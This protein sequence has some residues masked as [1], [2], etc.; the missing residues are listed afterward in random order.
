MKKVILLL[1]C[2]FIFNV[3]SATYKYEDVS[4]V[5]TI[6]GEQYVVSVRFQDNY[7]YSEDKDDESRYSLDTDFVTITKDSEI[8]L[9]N[10]PIMGSGFCLSEGKNTEQCNYDYEFS[11]NEIFDENG[12]A[13]ID[14]LPKFIKFDGLY[15]NNEADFLYYFGEEDE[16]LWNSLRNF[17]GDDDRV[18]NNQSDVWFNT[19]NKYEYE[20]DGFWD[21]FIHGD[22]VNIY[23]LP[24]SAYINRADN[25][26]KLLLEAS[27][28]N[29][30]TEDDLEKMQKYRNYSLTDL[31]DLDIPLSNS[32]YNVVFGDGGLYSEVIYGQTYM[33]TTGDIAYDEDREYTMGFLFYESFYNEGVAF[34]SGEFMQKEVSKVVRCSWLGEKTTEMFQMGFD[35]LKFA[36]I[37][38]GIL[39]GIIDI[40]K[41][42]IGKEDAGKKSVSVLI[43]RILAIIALILLPVI[44]EIIFELVNSIGI[45]DPICG[46]R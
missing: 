17:L 41:A 12:K 30:C 24:S 20:D 7:P 38:I 35:I 18:F 21:N 2:L 3:Y 26:R 9:K 8:F 31:H 45:N 34:L 43:K 13:I 15:G 14:N 46:I 4:Y 32:C 10:L 16:D 28:I 11:Y 6:N 44:V 23:D 36:G 5:V 33:A 27:N 42:V 39:L 1:S 19:S 29:V 37:L 40:F 25:I 22:S